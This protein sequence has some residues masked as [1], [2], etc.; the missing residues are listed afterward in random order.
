M[1]FRTGHINFPNCCVRDCSE[2]PFC[3]HV[4]PLQKDCSVKPD[5]SFR[6]VVGEGH[7][8]ISLI[9]CLSFFGSHGSKIH[10]NF[11]IEPRQLCDSGN[12][13][14]VSYL[15]RT[16]QPRTL[17]PFPAWGIQQELV[18]KDLPSANLRLFW[19]SS[20]NYFLSLK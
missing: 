14:R 17:A 9:I 11:V 8:Q 6:N 20:Q 13:K 4:F 5:P 1:C 16:A 2:N 7:A 19:K 12:K 10:D 18:V 15:H 3:F